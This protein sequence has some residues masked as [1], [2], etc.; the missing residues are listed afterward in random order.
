MRYSSKSYLTSLNIQVLG[1]INELVQQWI[2]EVS[3]AKGIPENIASTTRGKIFTFGSY[4]LG[5][6]TKGADID[7]LCVAPR[8]VERTDFFSSFV[9][10]LKQQVGLQIL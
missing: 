2:R 5:V 8:H 9:E 3:I 7:T 10:L 4:R 1:R 6:H